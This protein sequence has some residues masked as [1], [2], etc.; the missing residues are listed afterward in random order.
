MG[1][2]PEYAVVGEYSNHLSKKLSIIGYLGT[3]QYRSIVA[4]CQN[5]N[6][7]LIKEEGVYHLV[8]ESDKGPASYRLASEI[9]SSF[10]KYYIESALEAICREFQSQGVIASMSQEGDQFIIRFG[11]NQSVS[12]AV[13]FH[14]NSIHEAVFGASGNICEHITSQIEALL[15]APGATLQTEWKTEYYT[16]VDNHLVEVLNLK[17]L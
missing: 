11:T 6:I 7:M 3:N 16:N 8:L 14:E 2:Y 5:L 13:S 12:V 4:K 9:E 10:R 15:A 17:V 1:L